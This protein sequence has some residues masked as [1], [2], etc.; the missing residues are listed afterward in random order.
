MLVASALAVSMTNDSIEPLYL[1]N[2]RQRF[3]FVLLVNADI[4]D[5]Y[6]GDIVPP[7]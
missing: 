4:A 2:W 3:D 6:A 1:S 5:Q 7:A